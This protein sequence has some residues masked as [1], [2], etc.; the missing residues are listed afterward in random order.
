MNKPLIAFL[1][2]AGLTILYFK[3]RA[4]DAVKEK[5][6]QIR[7]RVSEFI[8]EAFPAISPSEKAVLSD[9]IVAPT[10]GCCG[11]ASFS[12]NDDTNLVNWHKCGEPV[13]QLWQTMVPFSNGL[14][15]I[16]KYP[17]FQPCTIIIPED[18]PGSE[19]TMKYWK[20]KDL[21][22][23]PVTETMSRF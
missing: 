6:N 7:G 20:G 16:G 12:E 17:F 22:I 18:P 4:S 14:T 21:F 23:T 2:G 5:E 3:M 13:S 19:M 1:T 11:S 9:K 15:D 10:A 8:D